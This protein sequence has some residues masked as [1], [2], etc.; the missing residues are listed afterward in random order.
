MSGAPD[1]SMLAPHLA[2]PALLSYLDGELSQEEMLVARTHVAAC[3][4]CRRHLTLLEE[5]IAAFVDAKAVIDPAQ[6]ADGEQRV[7]QFRERL[8]RHS[9]ELDAQRSFGEYIREH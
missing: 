6:L 5:Q 8:A 3:W 7:R 1:R 4:T 9:Q 2:E